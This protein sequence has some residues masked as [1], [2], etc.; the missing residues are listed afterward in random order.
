MK[1]LIVDDSKF[2]RGVYAPAD[3]AHGRGMHGGG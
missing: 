3:A 2:I 1:T